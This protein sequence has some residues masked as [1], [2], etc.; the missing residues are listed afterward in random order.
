MREKSEK[1]EYMAVSLQLLTIIP[2]QCGEPSDSVYHPQGSVLARG[3]ARLQLHQAA[4]PPDCSSTKLQLH[5]TAAP[6]NCSSTR[7]Q[8]HQTAAQPDCSSTRLQLHQTAAPPDCSPAAGFTW[9]QPD[10]CSAGFC[11]Q[12]CRETQPI[13]QLDLS[14]LHDLRMKT[15]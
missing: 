13:Q 6:P 9:S 7:L 5:Q 14:W 10:L 4:A 2:L 8:L 15:E 11:G 1:R 12:G 3:P